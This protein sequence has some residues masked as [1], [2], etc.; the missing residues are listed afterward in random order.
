MTTINSTTPNR[1]PGYCACG[2]HVPAGAGFYLTYFRRITCGEPMGD[3]L[4]CPIAYATITANNDQRRAQEI[5]WWN[6][7]TDEQRA[8]FN[9]HHLVDDSTCPK[10]GGNGK[11]YYANGEIGICYDCDGSGKY[12]HNNEGNN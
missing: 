8:T 10:C 5:A 4:H 12:R 2:A 11:Y 6:K 9:G 1:Y 7:M 3:G